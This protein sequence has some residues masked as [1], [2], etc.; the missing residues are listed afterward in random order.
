MKVLIVAEGKHERSGSLETLVRR[1]I[2]RDI[3][4]EID[5]VHD[6]L[7]KLTRLHP[8]DGFN[9][10]Y[11]RKALQWVQNAQKRGFDA[12]VLLVD[13]DRFPDRIKGIDKAQRTLSPT[14]MLPRALGVAIWAFDAW[15]LADENALSESLGRTVQCQPAP[16]TIRDPKS[17]CESLRDE[18]PN[19]QLGLAEMYDLV[20]KNIR[21][22][23]LEQRC[24]SGFKPF[25]ERV[26]S[27]ASVI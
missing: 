26:R 3:E 15:M 17:V 18:S 13:R 11:A 25:A 27:L 14:T 9:L 24:P 22:D 10:N 12:I 7:P 19:C 5:D 6:D 2:S 8:R 1:L 16:E 20:A 21:L 23:I 4:V